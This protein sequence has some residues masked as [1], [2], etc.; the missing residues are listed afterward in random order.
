MTGISGV[1]NNCPFPQINIYSYTQ[2]THICTYTYARSRHP[3]LFH[4]RLMSAPRCCARELSFGRLYEH[5]A[6]A[7]STWAAPRRGCEFAA[8]RRYIIRHIYIYTRR[9]VVAT[10]YYVYGCVVYA[11]LYIHARERIKSFRGYIT[12]L[13]E[14][15]CRYISRRRIEDI[16]I[17]IYI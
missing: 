14:S 9:H 3:S 10:P 2:H 12:V 7:A 6:A 5:A 17:Y 11:Q 4:G 1:C 15:V 13:F 16:Y 8:T